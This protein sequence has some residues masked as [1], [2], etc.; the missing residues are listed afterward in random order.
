[1]QYTTLGRT[2]LQVSVVGLGC[3]GPSRLG[4]R[5]GYGNSEADAELIVRQAIDQGVTLIDTATGYGTEAIVGRAVRESGKRDD[6]VI[7]TK[8]GA[9]GR[10]AD[11]YLAG[12]DQSLTHLGLDCIDLY[13]V[14]GVGR[15]ELPYV[16][17]E[18]V[19]ALLDARRAGKIRFLAVSERFETEPAHEMA[20]DLFANAEWAEVFDVLMVGFNLLNPS[21]RKHVLPHLQTHRIGTLAMFAV[22]KALTNAQRRAEVLE[23]LGHKADALDFLGDD[24]A[25]TDAGYRFCRHEPGIDVVLCGTGNAE[26]LKANIRSILQPPL[27]LE[28]QRRLSVLLGHQQSVSGS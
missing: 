26:H 5:E 12:I 28:D 22:R 15:E 2:G 27:Y 20:R 6:L 19:P 14:H 7:S 13:H 11:E 4:L 17:E 24:A 23:S 3:G 1:M 18:I 16:I 10:G 25:I 21:A 8:L 9:G